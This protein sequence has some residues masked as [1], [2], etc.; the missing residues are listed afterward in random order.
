MSAFLRWVAVAGV[1][2]LV[3]G[4]QQS[5]ESQQSA[6][7]SRGTTEAEQIAWVH[8]FEEGMAKAAEE[9]KP[10]MVDVFATW[11]APCKL[12]DEQVFSRADVAEASESFVTVRIDGDKH[13][14]LRE[15]LKVNSYP[16]VLFLMPDGTEIGRSIGAVSYTVMLEE[17]AKAKTEFDSRSG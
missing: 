8:D 16:S 15:K 6:E 14:D 5:R 7:R 9:G 17:M 4:C 11:C 1:A 13:P 10:V 2:A 12:L 3:V